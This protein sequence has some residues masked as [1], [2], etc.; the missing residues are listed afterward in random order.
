[1]TAQRIDGAYLPAFLAHPVRHCHAFLAALLA[2]A[3]AL[4]VSAA[5]ALAAK[6]FPVSQFSFYLSDY[7]YELGRIAKELK[8]TEPEIQGDI[9]AAEAAGNARLAA[10]S[11]E[12]LLTKRP[13]DGALWL[14]LARQ[15]AVASRSMIPTPMPCPP[16]S[17]ARAS[18]PI[19]CCR[20]PRRR[21]KR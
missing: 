20:R 1:M 5:P 9:K 2:V 4:L 7:D 18:R 14:E 11:M 16:R 15:L 3:S 6:T 21:R 12:Q 13:N 8:R 19:P 17:S 10:A